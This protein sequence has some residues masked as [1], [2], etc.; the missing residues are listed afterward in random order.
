MKSFA[1]KSK[2]KVK[3]IL[4]ILMLRSS[5]WTP[6]VN[7]CRGEKFNPRITCNR[8]KHA[9]FWT[10]NREREKRRGRKCLRVGAASRVRLLGGSADSPIQHSDHS[11]DSSFC[12]CLPFFCYGSKRA[13]ISLCTV[14]HWHL[15]LICLLHSTSSIPHLHPPSPHT[16]TTLTSL[17]YIPSPALSTF[18]SAS[19]F[20]TLSLTMHMPLPK[21]H[22]PGCHSNQFTSLSLFLSHTMHLNRRIGLSL[23]ET[24]RRGVGGGH[25][26]LLSSFLQF[27][28]THAPQSTDG[29][30]KRMRGITN[31]RE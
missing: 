28:S 6:A 24:E 25:I 10:R 22:S 4:F 16:I 30:T 20:L 7:I 1:V 9:V 17:H 26:S 29:K 27:L 21:S 14:T 2:C 5:C 13:W 19:L 8:L 15:P 3:Y 18:T 12:F 31:M 11:K 23:R